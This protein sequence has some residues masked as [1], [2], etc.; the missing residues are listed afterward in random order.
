M[1]SCIVY[2]KQLTMILIR[3]WEKVSALKIVNFNSLIMSIIKWGQYDSQLSQA[4][5]DKKLNSLLLRKPNCKVAD[6][7]AQQCRQQRRM[8][9]TFGFCLCQYDKNMLSGMIAS[10]VLFYV[11]EN[12]C[13]WVF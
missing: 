1:T 12:I 4:V 10:I 11:L 9:C 13:I 5:A 3:L 7:T 2:R 6:Q 8:N